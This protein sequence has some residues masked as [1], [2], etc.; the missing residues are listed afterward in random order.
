VSRLEFRVLD[1]AARP[2]SAWVLVTVAGAS[3][4]ITG[5]LAPW[6]IAL[7]GLAIAVSFARRRRPFRWQRS[8]WALDL[9]LAAIVA[10]SLAVALQDG[11]STIPLA[12]FAAL[13][14]GLQLLDARPRKTEFLLVT[15]AVFQ[16][17][18]AANLTDSVFFIPLLVATLLA[19]VWTLLVHT[20]RMEA[21]EAGDPGS[22]TQAVTPGLLRTTLLA[23]SLSIVLALLL[24]VALPRLRSSVV[25][26]SALAPTLATAG[27]SERVE[28]GDL[29]RIRQD[30]TVVLRVETLEGEPPGF[31]GDYWRGLAFDRFDGRSWSITPAGR[32]RIAGSAETG[33][34]LGHDPGEIDRVQR[35]VREPVAGGVLFAAG[36]VR[37][38][39]G[40]VRHLQRDASGGLYAGDQGDERV[41]YTV[42]TRRRAGWD[43]ER[44]RRD[45]AAPP[46]R[47]GERFLQ[48]PPLG[49]TVTEMAQRIVAGARSDADRVR[50]VETW[51]LRNGRY[52]DHPPETGER[53]P[54]EA[55]LLGELAGHCEYFASAMVVLLR[56]LGIPARLVNGFAG[57][58]EN[59][60][61]GFVE[62]TRSDAHTW[63]EVHYRSAGWVRYD[64]TP[65]D[66]RA[67][68]AAV[69]S[70]A[71]RLRDLGSA[72]ELWWF[73]R[74][75]GF[76]RSDQMRAL[77]EAWRAWQRARSGGLRERSRGR[78]TARRTAS[79]WP[80]DDRIPW[81]ALAG[82]L[83]VAGA[84]G[85]L[86]WRRRRDGDRSALPAAYAAA[87]RLLERRRLARPAA[88]TARAFARRVAASL[89]PAG[90]PFG[91]LTE[92]YLAARFGGRPWRSADED[93]AALRRA[94]RIKPD[95]S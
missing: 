24:F 78:W 95:R 91:A 21:L 63:V 51:L 67:R 45:A 33:V 53:P 43:D 35:V 46:L 40:G 71:T 82:A 25:T 27:F 81:R 23:S 39:Q 55:F 42:A 54:I 20:L 56:E 44:L 79:R 84:I 8:S 9:G 18:L 19:T 41:R 37:R 13:T 90:P 15:L 66:L 68:P 87:L 6:A 28:L 89:P 7:Q 14:Q 5:Q 92:R 60:I 38:L 30:P 86:R 50:A 48:R 4:W 16:L 32:H 12:H 58:R 76:D 3:L 52:T 77:K 26:A 73:Q 74:V 29:G 75:V 49:S 31:G 93:L 69:A 11:P 10:A 65:P 17:V 72:L 36:E 57:G 2:T 1:T 61:G 47:D 34:F 83:G 70:L 59:P 64:P 22:V 80:P 88:T 62:L 85:L 94:L